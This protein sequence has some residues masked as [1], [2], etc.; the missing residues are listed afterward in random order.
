MMEDGISMETTRILRHEH[1][2]LIVEAMEKGKDPITGEKI[3]SIPAVFTMEGVMNEWY[4]PAD[5]IE[6]PAF[7][8]FFERL[9]FRDD[10]PQGT[11]SSNTELAG[12][13]DRPW[14]RKIDGRP[15][16]GGMVNIWAGRDTGKNALRKI[17]SHGKDEVSIGYYASPM[18]K[19]GSYHD[20]AIDEDLSYIEIETDLFPDHLALVDLGACTPDMGCGLKNRV[21]SAKEIHDFLPPFFE[22]VMPQESGSSIGVQDPIIFTGGGNEIPVPR[23]VPRTNVL[24]GF[25]D[26]IRGKEGAIAA[27][28]GPKAPED[29]SW[30]FSASDGDALISRGWGTFKGVHS[31]VE[32][33]GTPEKKTAYKLPH[34]KI[35][36][37]SVKSVLRGIFAA[38]V[39]VQGGRGGLNVPEG[40]IPGIK[41]HLSGHYKQYDRE[42]P[43]NAEGDLARDWLYADE[44]EVLMELVD[45]GV[46]DWEEWK[47]SWGWE[48]KEEVEIH[49]SEDKSIYTERIMGLVSEDGEMGS[50]DPEEKGSGDPKEKGSGDPEPTEKAPCETCAG[51]AEKLT[52]LESEVKKRSSEIAFLREERD[53]RERG[54]LLDRLS[55]ATGLKG[56]R[57][58]KIL[59]ETKIL[60]E[61]DT[62]ES[63]DLILLKNVAI[64]AEMGRAT[65]KEIGSLGESEEPHPLGMFP[66]GATAGVAGIH[67]DPK[68]FKNLVPEV[69]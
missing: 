62:L 36:A 40:D 2:T 67:Y 22:M 31:W 11:I 49:N 12:Y 18:R 16:V 8:G 17:K 4:K 38:A 57:L 37:A 50:G 64:S 66:D 34:H 55:K 13:T 21:L 7:W 6:N 63:I 41:R 29:T 30:S 59:H 32:G 25:L 44:F 52:A 26:R 10:H 20:P 58:E 28:G 35:I 61:E 24:R 27:H 19:E 54:I 65:S 3:V 68:T 43:F 56:P 39:V 5:E 9:P 51:N 53:E 47:E 14:M 33:A 42:P 60:E 15:I 23:R 46:L 69:K 45:S 1:A 48:A